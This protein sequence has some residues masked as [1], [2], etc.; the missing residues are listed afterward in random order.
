MSEPA[1]PTV[2]RPSRRLFWRTLVL[3][4]IVAIVSI[5]I[6]VSRFDFSPWSLLVLIL[7]IPTA[8]LPI[9]AGRD[10][11]PVTLS[12]GRYLE[13]RGPWNTRRRIEPGENVRVKYYET[14]FGDN[15]PVRSMR[16]PVGVV[17][18]RWAVIFVDG[19]AQL[20]LSMWIWT[21]DDLRAIA[22]FLPAELSISAMPA[23]AA[24][25]VKKYPDY[26]TWLE[27]HSFVYTTLLLLAV[28]VAIAGAFAGFV[29]VVVGN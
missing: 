11:T 7:I 26:Y 29:F 3:F 2:L 27:R 1:V 25:I 14:P 9:A 4:A 6:A 22:R 16:G 24:T 18:K 12:P 10:A 23:T 8:V 17:N 5:Y 28:L 20:R 13:F 15:F 19:V 21:V